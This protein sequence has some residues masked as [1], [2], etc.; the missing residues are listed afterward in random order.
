MAAHISLPGS[1][2]V[3]VDYICEIGADIGS[4]IIVEGMDGMASLTQ[5]CRHPIY[6]PA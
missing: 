3:P 2:I 6:Y 5:Q 1:E 4:L